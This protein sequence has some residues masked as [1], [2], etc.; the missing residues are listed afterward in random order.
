MIFSIILLLGSAD[1]A[2]G[3]STLLVRNWKSDGELLT[4]LYS[5]SEECEL[6]NSLIYIC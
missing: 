4:I 3:S 1:P 5:S 2:N 6:L